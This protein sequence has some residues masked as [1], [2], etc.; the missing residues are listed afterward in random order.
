MRLLQKHAVLS[1]STLVL[2]IALV[3]ALPQLQK[4]QEIR[5]HA[6]T[7]A[8]AAL[9][10]SA[11]GSGD[12]S[13][14]SPCAFATADGKATAGTTIHVAPGDY[15]SVKI[16]K[17]GTATSPIHW[18]SDTKWGA[19]MSGNETSTVGIS[20]A[21]VNFEGFDV[22]GGANTQNLIELGSNS[23]A[24]GNHVHDSTRGGCTY[25]GG[26]VTG[27]STH[28]IGNLIEN[29][30]QGSP[31]S[32]NEFHGIYMDSND[33]VEN[34]VIINTPIGSGIHSYHNTT[35][36]T[37]INNTVMQAGADGILVGSDTGSNTGGYIANNIS[38]N[39]HRNGLSETGTAAGNTFVNNLSFGN[40]AGPN[41]FSSSAKSS[42]EIDADPMFVNAASKDFHLKPG[43]PAID[44]GAPA[45]APTTDFDG[46]PRPQGAAIDLGAFESG[47]AGGPSGAPAAGQPSGVVSPPFVAL[48]PCPTCVSP[49]IS[50][51]EGGAIVP[52]GEMPSSGMEEPSGAVANPGPS[53]SPCASGDNAVHDTAHH[54]HK[55]KSGGVSNG[56]QGLLQLIMQ[57]LNL[58]LKLLGGGQIDLPSSGVDVPSGTVSEPS[59]A[60]QNPC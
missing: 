52:S 13:Q 8:S 19:K 57:L 56:A 12:C 42:G 50:P 49:S 59:T 32:C 1:I 37:I 27:G 51:V 21:Y 23:T 48:A 54:K 44:K 9:Y 15:G 55:H 58:I 26:I 31:G 7:A 41:S 18:I 5:E 36:V 14:A 10:V 30:G 11:N 29:M 47:S 40:A 24:T 35:H 28:V 43:S 38:V 34:N 25:N 60:S 33:V 4:P 39:N 17:S 45:N 20:A 46:H 3:L 53:V 6:Q 22:T 16:S 2:F